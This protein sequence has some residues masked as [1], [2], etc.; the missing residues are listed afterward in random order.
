MI[1]TGLLGVLFSLVTLIF[2]IVPLP[3]TPDRVWDIIDTINGYLISGYQ[4]AQYLFDSTFY[5]Y[6]INIIIALVIAKPSIK[7]FMWLYNKIRGC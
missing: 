4:F 1:I 6:T 7:L 3:D 5:T 2:D